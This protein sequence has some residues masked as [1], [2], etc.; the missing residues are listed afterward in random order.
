MA[1]RLGRLLTLYV[2]R[3]TLYTGNALSKLCSCTCQ[4]CFPPTGLQSTTGRRL[5]RV[6]VRCTFHRFPSHSPIRPFIRH[7]PYSIL[8]TLVLSNSP[9]DQFVQTP[10]PPAPSLALDTRYIVVKREMK[11]RVRQPTP[12]RIYRGIQLHGR[13]EARR[14]DK[15]K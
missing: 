3:Y 10:P 11:A 2:I 7:S 14:D 12:L 9:R 1:E 8:Y 13:N 4:T 15:R 5:S 6:S